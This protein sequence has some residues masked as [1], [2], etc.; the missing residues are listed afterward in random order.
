MEE[1]VNWIAKHWYLTPKIQFKIVS[2]ALMFIGFWILKKFVLKIVYQKVSNVE[3]RY[4]W[5]H[6]V[7][8]TYYTVLIISIGAV[9]M[10]N[11]KSL[12]TFFG[13]ATAGLAIALQSIIVDIA[14]WMFILARKPFVV[15]DRIQVGEHAGDVIDIRFFQFTLNEIGNWVDSDQ[16]TG[17]IIH[18]PNGIVFTNTQANYHQGLGYL[19]NELQVMITFSSDWR[20]A[21]K[22]LNDIITSNYKNL[23]STA[24]KKLIETSKRYLISYSK[25]TPIVYLDVKEYGI[26]LTIRY[27]CPPRKRR[28]TEQEIW[29]NILEAFEKE[30]NIYFAYPTQSVQLGKLDYQNHNPNLD[31]TKK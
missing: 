30:D 5:G 9:W 13:L 14:G 2:S 16:S 12:A 6:W 19:W 17:R 25:L 1:I 15:G 8:S 28:S 11:F 3:E 21:K 10:E 22:I 23:P 7:K 31:G 29:V 24:R 4:K 26:R 20:K 18:I 27:I